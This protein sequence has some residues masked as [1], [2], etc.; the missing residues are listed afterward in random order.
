M[1]KTTVMVEFV[2]RGD[3]FDPQVITDK[4]K[5]TPTRFWTKEIDKRPEG[6]PPPLLENL[7]RIK[8]PELKTI[9]RDL[10]DKIIASGKK[11]KQIKH[12]FSLWQIDTGYQESNEIN[13]QTNLIYQLLKDKV[14]ILKELKSTM[15]LRYTLGI[16]LEIE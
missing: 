4:L 12:D 15:D 1:D 10:N 8:D 6:P 13:V 2:I 14:N 9:F 11:R 7:V 3:K 16:V 5:I